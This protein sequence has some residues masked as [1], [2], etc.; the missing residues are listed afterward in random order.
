MALQAGA[1][2]L[3]ALLLVNA[4]YYFQSPPPLAGDLAYVAR[5]TPGAAEAWRLTGR[6]AVEGRADAFLLGLYQV[7][8]HNR[9]GHLASLVGRYGYEG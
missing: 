9:N 6:R 8:V 1:A 4:V 7:V 3:V 2:A 5:H